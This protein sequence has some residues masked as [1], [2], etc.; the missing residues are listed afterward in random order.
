MVSNATHVRGMIRSASP[1]HGKVMGLILGRGKHQIVFYTRP[2]CSFQT[3]SLIVRIGR[4]PWPQIGATHTV[5]SKDF[6]KRVV[7]SKGLVVCYVVWWLGSITYGLGLWTSVRCVGM[8]VC[9]GH[10][11]Y[12]AQVPQHPWYMQMQYNTMKW[13][14]LCI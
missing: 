1:R 13:Q 10:D 2:R 6:Q 4:T 14:T 12:Q 9:F 3:V 8:V 11:G 5:H 7:Q